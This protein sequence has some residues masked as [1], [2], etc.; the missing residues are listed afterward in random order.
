ME[1]EF[2][3]ILIISAEFDL[4]LPRVSIFEVGS[5]DRLR[6][7]VLKMSILSCDSGD[8]DSP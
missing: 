1:H 7:L 5:D 2:E 4:L 8:C 3:R 6:I